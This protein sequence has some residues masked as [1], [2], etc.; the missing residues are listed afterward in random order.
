MHE[1][2]VGTRGLVGSTQRSGCCESEP[3]S[4]QKALFIIV[5]VALVLLVLA[6]LWGLPIRG[7]GG[8]IVE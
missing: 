3:M 5:I 2:S 7:E 4:A 8:V 6:A 1:P